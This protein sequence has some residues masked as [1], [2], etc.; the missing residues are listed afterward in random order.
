MVNDLYIKILHNQKH[1]NVLSMHKITLFLLFFILKALLFTQCIV[2]TQ[3]EYLFF[4]KEKDIDTIPPFGPLVVVFSEGIVDSSFP[5]FQFYPSFYS[6]TISYNNTRDTFY[7]KFPSP[8]DG[9]KKYVL[10]VSQPLYSNFGAVMYPMDDSLVFV[11]IAL[12]KE[13][14]NEFTD[15]DTIKDE[16]SGSLINIS[17]KDFYIIPDTIEKILIFPKDC[18]IKTSI[19]NSEKKVIFIYDE[20]V[21]VDTISLKKE[22]YPPY[23]I[24]IESSVK[25]TSGYYIV[26]KR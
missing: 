2:V 20:I 25:T 9:G 10:R 24:M 3:E 15:A 19:Y 6:F 23:F 5:Q 18:I 8:L 7:L 17:D 12:E 26:K 1:I 21:N 11:T 16:V 4:K 22:D 14:N 13:P